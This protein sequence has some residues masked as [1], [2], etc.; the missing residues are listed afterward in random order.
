M[1]LVL[2]LMTVLWV[3]QLVTRNAAVVDLGWTA[4]LALLHARWAWDHPGARSVALA[5]LV[6][7]WAARL[8]TH[9]FR[10]RIYRQPEEGRYQKLRHEWGRQA[11][12]NLLFFFWAQGVLAVLLALPYHQAGPWGL[13]Q[14]LGLALFAVGWVGESVADRQLARFKADPANRGR[15]CEEGLWDYSRHPN[16]FFELVIWASWSL[17]AGG[18]W[19]WLSPLALLGSVL[20]VTG[21]PPTEEQALRS[22]G[23]AYRRYQ[24]TTSALVPWFKRR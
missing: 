11:D 8:G 2:T 22:R 4:S 14:W 23:E 15:V 10:D 24:A 19:A 5:V 16:Y 9:L 3:G 20:F 18:G 17:L 12:R 13:A 1:I 7:L 6:G 21:I